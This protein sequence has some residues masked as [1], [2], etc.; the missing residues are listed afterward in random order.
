MRK[1]SAEDEGGTEGSVAII[2][3]T[4]KENY[5]MSLRWDV[6]ESRNQ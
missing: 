2:V 1:D 4:D 5:P 6:P 3:E